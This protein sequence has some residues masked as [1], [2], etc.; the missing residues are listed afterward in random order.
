MAKK[1]TKSV[2]RS[3]FEKMDLKEDKMMG[4]KERS[5]AD[6]R[7]DAK[8]GFPYKAMKKGKK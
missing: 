4:A 3:K 2:S 5:A 7:Q 8:E 1:P 6:R